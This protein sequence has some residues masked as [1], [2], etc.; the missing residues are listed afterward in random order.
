MF[1]NLR[2][3]GF[4]HTIL[5]MCGSRGVVVRESGALKNHES[6]EFLTS[7]G[8]DPL[9][10]HK[11]TKPSFNVGPS[12]ARQRNAI[13]MAFHWRSDIGPLLVVF[14]STLPSL[15]IK[16][17]K[18]GPPLTKLSGSAHAVISSYN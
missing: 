10:N 15:I 6:I 14:G 18:V 12:S 16:L 9:E 8:P 3:T 5:F 13:L 1:Y 11:A 2:E 7:T 17:V 4:R